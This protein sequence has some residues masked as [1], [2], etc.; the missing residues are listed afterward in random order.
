[1]LAGLEKLAREK[2]DARAIDRDERIPDEVKRG[3]AE[4]EAWPKSPV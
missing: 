3:A 1:V 2:I 4:L